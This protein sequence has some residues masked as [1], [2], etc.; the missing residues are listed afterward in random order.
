MECNTT[1]YQHFIKQKNEFLTPL[2]NTQMQCPDISRDR[3]ISQKMMAQDGTLNEI[4]SFNKSNESKQNSIVPKIALIA[5]GI[6]IT[7]IIALYHWFSI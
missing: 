2:I 7:Q 1:R 4:I 3:S 5:I 6:S